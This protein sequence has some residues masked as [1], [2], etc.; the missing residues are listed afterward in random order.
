MECCH[1]KQ[2]IV[3][4]VVQQM[5]R[6]CRDADI[7]SPS[8]ILNS[9]EKLG[10]ETDVGENLKIRQMHFSESFRIQL[11]FEID[12]IQAKNQRFSMRSII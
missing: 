5:N 2:E 12:G 9:L 1:D 11:F 10:V 3:A 7:Y 4:N 6:R 8:T